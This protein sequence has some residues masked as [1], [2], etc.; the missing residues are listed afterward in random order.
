MMPPPGRDLPGGSGGPGGSAT[1]PLPPEIEWRTPL[2]LLARN[3]RANPNRLGLVAASAEGGEMRLSFAAFAFAVDKAAVVLAGAGLRRGEHLGILM[4]NAAAAEYLLI[5]LGAM[6]LGAVVVPLNTRFALPELVAAVEDM[7][8]AMLAHEAALQG[9]AAALAEAVPRIAGRILRVGPGGGWAAA[10]A[11]ARPAGYPFPEIDENDLA[12]ILLTSGTT[13]RAKGV[14]LSHANAVAVGIAVAGGL[15]LGPQDTYQSPFPLFTSSGF[16]FNV[17]AAL[18]AGATL[19][20]EPAVD[21][22]AT[23]A[24]MTR[25]RTTVYCAVPAVFIFMLDAHD[26][27]H[28]DLSAM[29]VFDY[30]GAPMAREVIRRLARTFPHVELRQ[31]YGLTEAGPTGT[32]LAGRDALRKLGSLG[33]PMPLCDVRVMRPDLTEAAPG[34]MAEIVMRGPAIARGY[35]GRPDATAEAFHDGWLWTGDLGQ[36][37]DEGYLYYLDRGKDVII[38]GGFNITSMEVENAI[39]EHPAIREVAVIALPHDRLGED[40]CAVVVLRD[41]DL[42]PAI[43]DL[44]AFAA[45]RIADYKVP[46]HWHFVAELPRNPT[47]K[48]LKT[49]LRQMLRGGA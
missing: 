19:V 30:G 1:L 13:G 27:T 26:P 8:C 46:R 32:F 21:L 37:D 47:G 10:L 25:E 11:E 34:E 28:H 39:F 41:P 48:V 20:V 33:R 44:R 24:R 22:P 43:D 7:D 45:A 4:T 5:A 15:D 38:R 16:H 12:D 9:P 42:V 3:A 49:A 2:A 17:M 6:R 36:M 29:R 31:T 40:V 35:W 23:L 18:W 14:M